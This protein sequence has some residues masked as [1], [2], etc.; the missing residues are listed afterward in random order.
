MTFKLNLFALAAVLS[1]AA[2]GDSNHQAGT[3]PTSPPSVVVT[4]SFPRPTATRMVRIDGV[5]ATVAAR[6][7]VITLNE[8]V[9]RAE[10]DAVIQRLRSL[11]VNAIGQRLALRMLVATVANAGDEDAV[12]TALA[13][14]PGVAHAGYNPVVVTSRA[15]PRVAAEPAPQ[16]RALALPSVDRTLASVAVGRYWV[17]DIGLGAAHTVEDEL[18]ISSGPRIA[19]VDTGLPAG[20]ALLAA[21]R[22]TRVNATG[23]ALTG[24][25][26]SETVT[27]GRHV[28]GFAA[29]HSSSAAGVS[30]H[31]QVLM[32]DVQGDECRGL[33]SLFGCPFDIGRVF[34]TDLASGLETAI[35]SSARVVNVSWGDTSECRDARAARI[36]ARLGF[37]AQHAAVVN[38]AR[39]KDKL[40]VFSSGNNCEKA[41]DQLLPDAMRSSEDSWQS[42][43]LI[44]GASTEAG[45]DA[46]FSR[47]GRVVN[48]LAPGEAVSYGDS[49]L[50]GTS[51][52]TP[53]VTGSAAVVLGINPA[54]SAP[55]ARHLLIQGAEATL[56]FA[57]AAAAAYRGYA[58]SN[59]STPNRLL[60]TGNSARAAKLTRNAALTTLPAV[61]LAKGERKTVQ[62]DVDIP[63]TGV[64]ALDVVFLIDVSG[65]YRDDIATLKRQAGAIVD[66]LL[67]RGIDVQFG[68]SE[69]SDFPIGDFGDSGDSAFRRLTRITGDKA[70]VLAGIDALSIKSGDDDPESQLEAL[71]QVATGA[72]R[73]INRD[74][75]HNAAAGDTAPQPMGFRPGAARVVLFATDAP[76]HDRDRESTYPGAGFTETVSVLKAQGIRVV[77]LQSGSIDSAAADIARLVSATGGAAYQLSSD[78]AQI[79]QAIAA[80]VDATLAELELS[81][82]RVAGADWVVEVTQDKTKARPGEKVRFTATLQG[83]RSESVDRLAYDLYLW[84]RGNGQALIQRVKIPVEVRS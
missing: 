78:S 54:L 49:V 8:D 28:T 68:V 74:G 34:R 12:I 3:S 37:R 52:S 5:S 19:I 42:N 69:F 44:V 66:A 40:V 56:S 15:N 48:L 14:M 77:A 26:D 58:G 13:A 64:R 9:S 70:A 24:D 67:A 36:E 39:R 45:R 59:A 79:A 71:Y 2:C 31:A 76:F 51:F 1:L 53:I 6:Q 10:Y 84:V 75:T 11:P 17:D 55:E 18:A 82:E 50:D 22:V 29:G 41:D 62:F 7:A 81:V 43:A 83:Q 72:G 20:Q 32:V 4:D 47:M 16:R 65:S 30:R 33:L 35:D 46:L 21:G 73:D 61:Q 63:A 60:N 27:H 38:L 25:P 80:G 57:D 23:A